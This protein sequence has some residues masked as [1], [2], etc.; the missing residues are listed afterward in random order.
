MTDAF[1]VNLASETEGTIA[2]AMFN[3]PVGS[4]ISNLLEPWF[5]YGYLDGSERYYEV[6]VR[7]I[8]EDHNLF[9]GMVADLDWPVAKHAI[10]VVEQYR[11]NNPSDPIVALQNALV[12]LRVAQELLNLYSS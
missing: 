8:S 7:E 12:E 1:H 10:Q 3:E 9:N 4:M 11:A 5:C 2:L 6:P